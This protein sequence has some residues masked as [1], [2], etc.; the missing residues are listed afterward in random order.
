MSFQLSD[1]G[2]FSA[3]RTGLLRGDDFPLIAVQR[4]GYRG[5]FGRRALNEHAA[6]HLIF[7]APGPILGVALRSKMS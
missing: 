4:V 6:D 2:T 7:R 1:A 3:L 5:F